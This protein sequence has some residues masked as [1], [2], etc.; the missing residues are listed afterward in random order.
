VVFSRGSASAIRTPPSF[1]P[2]RNSCVGLCLRAGY[3]PV[4]PAGCALPTWSAG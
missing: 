1:L 2:V 3:L 4:G